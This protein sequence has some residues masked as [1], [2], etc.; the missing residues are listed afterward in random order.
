MHG[1]GTFTRPDGSLYIGTMRDGKPH[2]RGFLSHGEVGVTYRGDLVDG[3]FH[4]QGELTFPDGR[5]Y[6]GEFHEGERH[7]DGVEYS[8]DGAVSKEGN[9]V[10]GVLQV[11]L[12]KI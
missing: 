8:K 11:A 9:W 3:T 1:K 7:G 4:G 10:E 6:V 5:K 12:K 2:G